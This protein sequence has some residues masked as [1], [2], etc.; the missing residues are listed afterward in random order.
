MDISNSLIAGLVVI[1]LLSVM[2]YLSH[3]TRI[4]TSWITWCRDIYHLRSLPSPPGRWFWGNALEVCQG[5]L[6][7]QTKILVSRPAERIHGAQGKL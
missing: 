1:L 4:V 2:V 3:V 5:F 6:M 7:L